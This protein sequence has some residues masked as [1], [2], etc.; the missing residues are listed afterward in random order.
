MLKYLLLIML[1]GVVICCDV[2]ILFVDWTSICFEYF[3]VSNCIMIHS[4]IKQLR[5]VSELEPRIV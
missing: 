2:L 5:N 4:I 3:H 1:N